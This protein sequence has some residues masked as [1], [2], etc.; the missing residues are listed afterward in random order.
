MKARAAVFALAL[1]TAAPVLAEPPGLPAELVKAFTFTRIDP[2]PEPNAVPIYTEAT[3]SASSEVWDK[4]GNGERVV[5]NVTRPTLT[6]V[7]PGPGKATGAAVIVAPGGGFAMLSMDN[8]GWPVAKWLADR[9]IAAFILK[10]RLLPTPA[11]EATH[12]KQSMEMIA[13]SMARKDGPT[14][15]KAPLATQ[16]ALAA[17][18]LIR[19]N[20]AKWGVDP[21]RVGMIGFSAGAMTSLRA[22]LEGGPADRPNFFGYIYGPMGPV[23][24]PA[25]APPMFAALAMD[26]ALFGGR[27]F[28]IVD[29]WKKAGRP[30]ELHAYEQGNHG[31]GMGRPGT[32][33]T[34]TMPAFHAWLD[35]RG[36]LKPAK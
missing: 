9:G 18:K 36:L 17:L 12:T 5:R 11:D 1:L 28:A 20:S 14:D 32:T 29:A 31:Y 3:G 25:D 6:P 24:V 21:N 23:E 16:D 7:L 10:Y 35:S 33:T 19:A 30:V 13:A 8:E 22:V 2:V 27:G 34:M 4:M 15:I 26:D